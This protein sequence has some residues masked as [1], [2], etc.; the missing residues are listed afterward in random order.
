MHHRLRLRCTQAF[1]ALSLA[2]LPAA[3][4]VAEDDRSQETMDGSDELRRRRD[5]G[6]GTADAG[7]Q[8]DSGST[9]AT[10]AGTVD[11]GAPIASS[12]TALCATAGCTNYYVS[13]SGSDG[14]AGTSAGSP[15]QT[16]AKV[17]AMR[18]AIKAGDTILFKRGDS[19]VGQLKWE[20]SGTANARITFGNYG[21]G[22]LPIFQL[23]PGSTVPLENR[24]LFY[25]GGASY[26]TVDGFKITDLNIAASPAQVADHAMFAYT[27]TA[28]RFESYTTN[29][30]QNIVQNCDISL[31]GMGVVFNGQDN[32]TIANSR[33]TNLK[34]LVNTCGAPGTQASW[35]DYG[36]N[37]ITIVGS[38]NTIKGN[39]F[40]GNWATSCDFGTNGGAIEFFS[41]SSHN[42]VIGNTMVDC[43]GIA[44]FGSTTDAT[45]DDTLFAYNLFINNGGLSWV[46]G[47]GV[48]ASKTTNIQYFNNTIIST[49]ADRFIKGI[50]DGNGNLIRETI[51]LGW[52]GSPSTT[53]FNLKNNIFY[54][55]SGIDVVRPGADMSK[56]VH[57]NNVYELS[58]GSAT[59][60]AL[61]ASEKTS[62]AALFLDTSASNP[63]FWNA[64]PVPGS[65]AIGAGQP[66]GFTVDLKGRTV[67]NPPDV[68]ALQH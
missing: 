53:V 27:G 57:E 12:P 6:A 14:N 24:N 34:N 36:A 18:S 10:D 60:F 22:N 39:Y 64:T 15:W 50:P 21:T 26:I 59:N 40:E 63:T 62:S 3:C 66:L 51:L 52:S 35:E 54:L 49:P 47:S 1:V 67:T 17:Y 28:I 19:F 23:T 2:A 43:G 7:G 29:L 48:F 37:G 13:T 58:A 32:G 25:F 42:R 9:G 44:E 56:V 38:S 5:A 33:I 16:M 41:G 45:L 11:S 20:K 8:V 61:G 68:G 30:T 4:S 31:V 46:N 55:A 65:P